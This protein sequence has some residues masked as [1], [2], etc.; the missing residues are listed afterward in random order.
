[1]RKIPR[2]CVLVSVFV[3]VLASC[4]GSD[5][6]VATTT[7]T[8]GP[9][10][11]TTAVAST[12]TTTE[13]P[14]LLVWAP[15]GSAECATLT[16]PLDH[17]D[18]AKG[19]IDLVVAR[20]PAGQP[21]ERV[22]VLLYNPGGPGGPGVPIVTD[23]ADDVFSDDLLRRFDVVSW[24][25]R[26][27]SAGTEVD[28]VDDPDSFL[29]LDPTP[30]TAEEAAL[31]EAQA[32][33]FAAGCAERSGD[34]LPY[35]STVSTARDMDLLREA[36][37]EEQISYLGQSYGTALGS[38]YATL[39][40]ERV[41]AMVLDGAFDLSAASTDWW[42]PQA[43]A[44]EQA[45]T[46]ALE[47]CASNQGCR[48]HSDG[49][50]FTAFDELMA[51]LDAEPLIVEGTE[52]GLGHT[53]EAVVQGLHFEENW[54]MLMRALDYAWEGDGTALSE[55]I[56]AVDIDP[57]SA[58]SIQCLDWPR[59]TWE[60]SPTVIDQVLAVAPRLGP[61]QVEGIALCS[62]WAAEPNPP[63][64]LTG[65]GAGPILVVGT[66]GDVA[67]PLE[68]S[69][70]LAQHL[71]QSVF[72]VVER[73]AHCAYHPKWEGVT[74]FDTK[75]VTTTVDRYL[76]DLELPANESVCEHGNPQLQ[77]PG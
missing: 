68:S 20:L 9:V 74:L 67:T 40:P 10:T 71:E 4:T 43:A 58:T 48:F 5:V 63:P 77:P 23:W 26:G 27:V 2:V 12:T 8:T 14:A 39:F 19:T 31:I 72:L 51:R 28:C 55:I 3:L 64:P 53:I 52:V 37:G 1:M 24:D 57:E 61:F 18:P 15:C 42:V 70:D 49:D 46:A 16:V 22:G 17:D 44:A 56:G 54:P 13:P 7:T 60:P 69:R 62:V 65:S 45:L 41:R 33:E 34:V 59:D 75:C 25:P 11:T 30:E 35:L 76:I 50:P 36:L 29:G 66:T 47:Q 6:E 38:V 21:N 32:T 73:N